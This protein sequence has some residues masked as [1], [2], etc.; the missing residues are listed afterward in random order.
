MKRSISKIMMTAA[1]AVA[2]ITSGMAQ[3]NLGAE[4]GCPPV[5]GRGTP[6]ALS[7]LADV[8]GNLTAANTI[9]TC[10]NAYKLDKKIFVTAGKSITINPGTVIYADPAAAAAANA[11]VISRG[12]KIFAA[13]KESCPIVFTATG[14][15][16]DGSFNT[17]Q[18]LWGG[19]VLLGKATNNLTTGCGSLVVAPGVGLIEGIAAADP[20]SYYGADLSGVVTGFSGTPAVVETFD[21]NDNSG[22]MKYVSIRHGG[23]TIATNNELNGLTLGSVGRGTTLEYIEIV[24]NSDDGVEFFGGVPQLKYAAVF[25]SDDDNFDWDHGFSGKGQFWYTLMAAGRGDHG[26]EIDSDDNN[27]G[28]Y[29]ISNPTIYNY[30]C[31]GRNN[32]SDMAIEAK[33]GTGGSIRSSIFANFVNGPRLSITGN[34]NYTVYGNWNAIPPVFVLENNTFVNMTGTNFIINGATPADTAKMLSQNSFVASLAGFDYTH[35]YNFGLN[36]VTSAVTDQVDPTPNPA[37]A[38]ASTPPSDGFFTPTNYRGAFCTGCPSWLANWSFASWV[39]SNNGLVPCPNDINNDGVVNIT[40][41]N[42]V[43]GAFGTSCD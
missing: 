9:L 27:C 11:L 23:A 30:T 8:N 15:P 36:S 26:M 38:S 22:I 34:A 16:L 41:F 43:L 5:S 21:D 6:I 1:M 12:G 18:Q 10:N 35:A 19:V 14:D 4:C 42:S 24:A 25:Y 17:P 3:T 13:G 7:T 28:N 2:G 33:E 39:D 20:R 40:D 29:P 31:I 37:V 32:A